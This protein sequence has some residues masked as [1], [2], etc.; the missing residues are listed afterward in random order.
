MPTRLP[1]ADAV[2]PPRPSLPPTLPPI[3]PPTPRP[4]SHLH[5]VPTGT[6]SQATPATRE[7]AAANAAA[8]DAFVRRGGGGGGG[9]SPAGGGGGG[10]GQG[11]PQGLSVMAMG[12]FELEAGNSVEYVNVTQVRNC[13]IEDTHTHTHTQSRVLPSLCSL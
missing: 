4:R 2:H 9:V 3:H 1:Y 8:Q 7:T 13:R 12:V 5:E 10:G 6:P 11:Q